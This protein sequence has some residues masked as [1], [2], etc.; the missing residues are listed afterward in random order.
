M[1]K[2]ISNRAQV[3]ISNNVQNILRNLMIADWHSEPHQQ[4]QNP[5]E[6]CYQ[7]VKRL[8][9]TLIDCTGAPPALWYHAILHTCFILNHTFNASIGYAV[10]MTILTGITQDISPILQFEWYGF[11]YYRE[12]E[13]E[14]PSTPY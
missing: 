14:F 5:A 13:A 9:N 8:T 6:R 11:V 2:L 7:D 4:H 1:V 10:P 12:E 3:E